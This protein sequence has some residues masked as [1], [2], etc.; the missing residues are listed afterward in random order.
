M[1][2]IDL[3]SWI[4]LAAVVAFII[5][6]ASTAELVS[7]WFV[8]GSLAAFGAAM[9][10]AGLPAQIAVFLAVS[11]A[12]LVLLRPVVRRKLEPKIVPTNADR[13]IGLVATVTAGALPGEV[14]RASVDGQSWSAVCRDPISPGDRARVA[15]IEGVKLVLEKI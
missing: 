3:M 15:S 2:Q 13:V 11:V 10:G 14:G 5:I 8:V 6:E 12:A 1:P 7:I 4:W 9:L